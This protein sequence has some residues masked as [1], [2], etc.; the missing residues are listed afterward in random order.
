[1]LDRLHIHPDYVLDD[2]RSKGSND[3]T[4]RLYARHVS[5]PRPTEEEFVLWEY[6]V[7]P[8]VL[9][10]S[11]SPVLRS[12][13]LNKFRIFDGDE[14]EDGLVGAHFPPAIDPLQVIGLDDGPEAIWQALLLCMTRNFIGQRWHGNYARRSLLFRND[15][16][17][18]KVS[19]MREKELLNYGP[20]PVFPDRIFVPKVVSIYR[21][22]ERI[23]VVR[24]CWWSKWG[25]LYRVKVPFAR[26]GS[27]I[28]FGDF[29]KENLYKYN[30]GIR[31]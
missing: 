30:C 1:M 22:V 11:S 23:D 5:T 25:G 15:E 28:S 27:T 12:R 6:R 19:K 8:F 9:F 4:L 7:D 13:G 29:K 31:F 20:V 18:V 17:P 3:N 26:N 14:V 2:Y 16:V 10:H 24:F 21:G